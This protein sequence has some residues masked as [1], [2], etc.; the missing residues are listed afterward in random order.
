[1]LTSI[2]LFQWND[3]KKFKAARKSL[4]AWVDAEVNQGPICPVG[5]LK[6]VLPVLDKLRYVIDNRGSWCDGGKFTEALDHLQA[7]VD[8]PDAPVNVS[9]A[10][11]ACGTSGGC[12]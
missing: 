7:W 12:G 4:Q 2:P 6:I 3:K 11:A 8:D 5:A 1:M 10:G 9:A